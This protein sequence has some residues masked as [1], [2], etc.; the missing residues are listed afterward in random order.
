MRPSDARLQAEAAV[1]DKGDDEAKMTE[2]DN[3]HTEDTI[4]W[5]GDESDWNRVRKALKNLPRDGLKLDLWADWL[6]DLIGDGM[7]A[8][9]R[10]KGDDSAESLGVVA[11]ST[12]RSQ[13]HPRR[14]WILAILREH[15][16][17][18]A[19]IFISINPD[20]AH[21]LQGKEL[22]S[23]FVYPDSR[24]HLYDLFVMAGL[25]QNTVSRDS[26]PGP[27]LPPPTTRGPHLAS[28]QLFG[29][30]DFWSQSSGLVL[31]GSTASAPQLRDEVGDASVS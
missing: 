10:L 19:V 5:T 24:A 13:E 30:G 8:P 26:T 11:N 27:Y 17:M 3:A 1:E 15:V 18:P 23:C 22:R 2:S 20:I 31:L 9:P 21:L 16:N 28:S 25:V 7:F 6:S 14:E 29:Q 12:S 4:I